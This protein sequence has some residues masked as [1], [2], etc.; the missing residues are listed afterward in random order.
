MIALS[1]LSR[2][3]ESRADKRP[4]L[5]DLRESGCMPADTKLMRADNGQEISLGELVLCQEQ[6]LVWSV[7]EHQRLVPARLVKAF[8]SGIKP[9]F[10]LRLA[11]GRSVNATA[12]HP[13]LT[14]D[15]WT[16]LDALEP[17]S[18]I[19]TP[20]RLPAPLQPNADWT[21]DELMLLAHLLGDGTMG[22][23]FKY[24]TADPANKE[25]V[26]GLARRLFGI[27]TEG[28]K[29][30]NTWQLWFPSPYRLTHGVHHPMRNWLEPHGLWKSRAWT[31]FCPES[32]FGLPDAQVA[33]FLRHL[34]ATDG[35]IT[36]GRNGRGPIVQHLLRHHQP[37][38]GPRRPAP[39][40]PPRG[41]VHHRHLQEA[42]GRPSR[43]RRPPALPRRLHVRIQ[44]AASQAR[45]L[46]DGRL[47]RGTGRV[48]PRGP[49]HPRR[50]Q[51]EPERRPGAVAG[52]GQG[53]GGRP[54]GGGDPTPARGRV[55]GGLLRLLPARHRAT[56]PAG[57]PAIA[58]PA[59]PS[60]VGSE[61]LADIATSDVSGTRSS[62]SPRS[63]TSPRSTPPSRAPTTS[64]PTAWS[65]T[66]R[67]EQDA[68][69]VMFLYRDEV[70]NRDS[71][72]QGTA[73][74]IVA[75]HRNGPTGV[76][77]LAFLDHYTRF[78][79]MAR[80]V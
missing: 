69:V 71:P 33:L 4:V 2:N 61:E 45:F 53:R 68:D 70:Y 8:P 44:G 38:A 9:V 78:A 27:E 18:F 47:P 31:K 35:S 1:Q 59:S 72:D 20:R 62:R 52:R 49:G 40:P 41:P 32:I 7:D 64:W 48:H 60:I 14:I 23:S 80:G 29:V 22:S 74:I 37:A 67:F 12:N 6:P 79:N 25:L 16:R 34:W 13:F 56:A 39:P 57:S 76:T 15:G 42:A 3:L 50:D 51:G 21:D 43:R 5:A 30:G 65:P 17:G 46:R 11:S 10:T 36:I 66:T 55:W 19:A 75:K 28:D 54:P 26:E 77:H 73:E 58:W 63:A 24:A